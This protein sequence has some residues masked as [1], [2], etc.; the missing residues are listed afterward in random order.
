[1]IITYNRHLLSSLMIVTYNRHLRSSLMIITYNH[2]LRSSLMIVTYDHPLRSS[3][4]IVTYDCHLRSSLTI[5]TYNHK[6]IFIVQAPEISC[7]INFEEII[8]HLQDVASNRFHILTFRGYSNFPEYE[9]T[10]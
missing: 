3:L 5:V 10:I 2:H 1:M 6:N 4:M 8:Q 9:F 7:G